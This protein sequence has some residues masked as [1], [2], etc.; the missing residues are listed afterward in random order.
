MKFRFLPLALLLLFSYG[1]MLGQ[2]VEFETTYEGASFTFGITSNSGSVVSIDWGTGAG[3]ENA[4]IAGFAVTCPYALSGTSTIKIYDD[5]LLNVNFFGSEKKIQAVKLNSTTLNSFACTS[6]SDVT[7]IDLSQVPN[8]QGLNLEECGLTSINLTGVTNLTSLQLN[9][10][11]I[12]NLN[13]DLN[14]NLA[15]LNVK[16]TPISVL[17][18]SENEALISLYTSNSGI[19]ELD[20]SANTELQVL[21]CFES[22]MTALDV[23]GN[24][25]L[26]EIWC[27]DNTIGVLDVSNMPDLEVLRCN[28]NSLQVLNLSASDKL[29]TLVCDN[30]ALETLVVNP[31]CYTVLTIL[32]ISNN[33]LTIDQFPKVQVTTTG[34][35]NIKHIP[36]NINVVKVKFLADGQS[37]D[38]SAL[39]AEGTGTTNLR[40]CKS[41]LTANWAG[42]TNTSGMVSFPSTHYDTEMYVYAQKAFFGGPVR[43][44]NF[45]ITGT[46]VGIDAEKTDEA[47]T[48]YPS[49]FTTDVKINCKDGVSVRIFDVMGKVVYSSALS[50]DEELLNLSKLSTGM[51]ILQ[52]D[53]VNA[54]YTKK[55]V[56]Q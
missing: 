9:G 8:L 17:N 28:N 34:G 35:K 22:N 37:I 44:D 56:K 10:N 12:A 2:N 41:G 40:I 16:N 19:T 50:G 54:S 29:T 38:V 42:Y 23:S 45:T 32:D 53:V 14:T 55:I 6:N 18:L 48:V 30:N 21:E 26:R 25:K 36:Q 52:V 11:P 1:N 13:V 27:R 24:N 5:N 15:T 47:L 51:Y 49:V 4:T 43:S 3:P 39:Y 46:P 33:K 20:L 31:G 7:S